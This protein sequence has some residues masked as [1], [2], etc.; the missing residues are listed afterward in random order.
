M[1]PGERSPWTTPFACAWA[2]AAAT[3]AIAV[4]TSPGRSRP[5]RASS[6]ARLPPSSSSRTRATRGGPAAPRLVHHLDQPDQVRMVELAEQRRLPRLPLR[7]AGD[8]HLDRDGLARRAGERRARP[9]PSRRGRAASRGC[10]RGRRAA[11]SPRF[12][13]QSAADMTGTVGRSGRPPAPVVH[14]PRPVHRC[15]TPGSA[16]ATGLATVGRCRSRPRA[17]VLVVG[18]GLAGLSAASAC[19]RPAATSMSSRPASHAGGR[20]ATE[21]S[22]VSSSTGGSRCSTPATPAPPIST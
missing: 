16:A 14:R 4:T 17:E 22:T 5:R 20:L 12:L 19:A 3:G 10:T 21:R 6:A 18:A 9:R 2:S 11:R 1:L 7:I 15:P 13:G 8:E